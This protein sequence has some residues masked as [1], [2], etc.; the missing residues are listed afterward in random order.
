MYFPCEYVYISMMAFNYVQI[1][2]FYLV[3][4][5]ILVILAFSNT[6]VLQKKMTSL[7]NVSLYI[8]L[9]FP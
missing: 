4:F 8:C 9:I 3:I 2:Q 7:I 6:L 1:M 5:L